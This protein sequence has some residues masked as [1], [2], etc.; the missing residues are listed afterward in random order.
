VRV[1]YIED[2]K[3][4]YEEPIVVINNSSK[5]I[6]AILTDHGKNIAVAWQQKNPNGDTYTYL[7]V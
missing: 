1:Y 2:G 3:N 6:K 7:E 4:I 5:V